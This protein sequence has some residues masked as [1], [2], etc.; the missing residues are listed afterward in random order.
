MKSLKNQIAVITGASSGIGNAIALRLAKHG[1]RLHLVSRNPEKLKEIKATIESAS[2]SVFTY[3]AD[4][5]LDDSILGLLERLKQN[6]QCVEILVHSAGVI[7][8]G[9]ISQAT[10]EDLDWQYRI[11]VRAPY[12]LT[13]GLLPQLRS[14]SGQVVF[15]NSTAGLV[16]R[17]GIGQYAATKYALRAMADTLRDEENEHGL[18]V[19]S[20]FPGRTA[21]PMQA[22]VHEKEGRAYTPALLLQPS[23][24]A[25]VVVDALCAPRS[26]EVTDIK[27]RPAKKLES[28]KKN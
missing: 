15:V 24:V 27:L 14:A 10:V 13:Q 20:I 26:T 19:L 25:K 6:L 12:I 23:D 1:A 9:S 7:S 28:K 21:T 8:L 16:A 22:A 2:G 5:A 17:P 11:N 4:L 18:R 3:Q